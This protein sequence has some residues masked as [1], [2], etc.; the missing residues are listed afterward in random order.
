MAHHRKSHKQKKRQSRRSLSNRR[1]HRTHKRTARM[2]RR[3]SYK[4]R[5]GNGL[6]GY[7]PADYSPTGTIN[8][9]VMVPPNYIEYNKDVSAIPFGMSTRN[10]PLPPPLL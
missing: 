1:R 5:G 7:A 6:N 3:R 8:P 2:S 10:P 9:A 4:S